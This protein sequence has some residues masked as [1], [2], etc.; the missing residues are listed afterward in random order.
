LASLNIC[1]KIAMDGLQL[2]ELVAGLAGSSSSNAASAGVLPGAA[3]AAATAVVRDVP[4]DASGSSVSTAST[5]DAAAAQAAAARWLSAEH[6][7]TTAAEASSMA[8]AA[9]AAEV[10]IPPSPVAA[11]RPVISQKVSPCQLMCLSLDCHFVGMSADVMTTA[12]QQL[13]NLKVRMAQEGCR[14]KEAAPWEHC[15]CGLS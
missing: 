2:L 5:E 15:W 6:D 12:L 4:Q 8:A 13:H 3:A 9:A 7:G 11:A 10:D 1:G 14:R